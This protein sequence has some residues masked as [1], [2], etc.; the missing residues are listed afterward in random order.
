MFYKFKVSSRGFTLIELIIVLVLLAI[1]AVVAAPRIIDVS[2]NAKIASLNNIAAQMITIIELVK[3]KARVSGKSPVSSNPGA[4]QSEFIVDFGIGSTEVDFRNLCPESRG[5]LGDRL[6]FVD[7]IEFDSD[8]LETRTNNQ[9]TLVGYQV[10]DS[11]TPANQGCY[12]I[13]DSFGNPDCTVRVV[14]E[15]C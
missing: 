3:N 5:E 6:D 4:G 12:I 14:T 10:P 15:D 11:G 13:Y 8:T 9:Y 7:F 1:L 2:S